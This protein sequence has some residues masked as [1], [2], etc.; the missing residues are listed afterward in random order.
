MPDRCNEFFPEFFPGFHL[1]LAIAA[2]LALGVGAAHSEVIVLQSQVTD[3]ASG[4]VLEDDVVL[5]VP[6]NRTVKLLLKPS[7]ATKT[8]AG[9]FDGKVDEYGHARLPNLNDKPAQQFDAGTVAT[10]SHQDRN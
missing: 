10:G 9:P 8:I 5:H 1:T 7:N 4:K 3:I 2:G 6:A